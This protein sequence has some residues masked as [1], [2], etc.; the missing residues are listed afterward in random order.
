MASPKNTTTTSRQRFASKRNISIVISCASGI[1][2]GWAAYLGHWAVFS[3]FMLFTLTL[4]PAAFAMGIFGIVGLLRRRLRHQAPSG[5]SVISL[6]FAATFWLSIF[7]FAQV[8]GM[9]NAN[10]AGI[11]IERLTH[12]GNSQS[13]PRAWLGLR[14][15]GRMRLADTNS[16]LGIVA[17]SECVV[18]DAWW[19]TCYHCRV[20]GV[21]K[22]ICV[23]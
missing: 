12:G 22:E 7:V 2:C 5:R 6:S 11:A 18:R 3:P 15:R 20:D 4:A 14:P 13:M 1:P 16:G 9:L 10:A 17:D 21:L 23:D 8:D 19:Y